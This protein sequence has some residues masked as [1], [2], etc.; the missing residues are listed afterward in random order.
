[1]TYFS[2]RPLIGLSSDDIYAIQQLYGAKRVNRWA[3][4]SP[5]HAALIAR[6]KTMQ[7]RQLEPPQNTIQSSK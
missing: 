5:E 6:Y 4:V 3:T 7:Q 2:Y 1:M